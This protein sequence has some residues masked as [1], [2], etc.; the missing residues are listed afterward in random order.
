LGR[1]NDIEIML[2]G[3]GGKS[4]FNIG[5]QI[6]ITLAGYISDDKAM[7]LHYCASDLI[8]VPS[9]VDNLPNTLLEGMACGLPVVALNVGGIKDA[10]KDGINGYLVGEY[11][12][13]KILQKIL[14]I[15]D[16]PVKSSEMGNKSRQIIEEHFSYSVQAK[17]FD[18]LYED[19]L[20]KNDR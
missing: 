6:P 5:I 8:V 15:I 4:W 20:N 11:S 17:R 12:A 2:V 16:N 10:V 9:S 1:R 19:I 14:S 13:S 18:K 3:V 7:A